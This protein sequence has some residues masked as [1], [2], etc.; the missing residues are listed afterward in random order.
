M[1]KS[2]MIRNLIKADP[3]RSLTSL[4][5]EAQCS[6]SLVRQVKRGCIQYTGM[7][8]YTMQDPQIILD[9][10][11]TAVNGS[12]DITLDCI[13]TLI[14]SLEWSSEGANELRGLLS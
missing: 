9:S 7:H 4:A 2:E 12:E 3:S 14:N 8:V 1:S 13:V 10:L 5:L 6:V 11:I